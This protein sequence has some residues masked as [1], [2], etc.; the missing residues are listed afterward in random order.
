VNAIFGDPKRHQFYSCR[1]G[2]EAD[3]HFGPRGGRKQGAA[4][5]CYHC[6]GKSKGHAAVTEQL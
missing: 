3:P 5:V 1:A 2:F 6:G 4:R